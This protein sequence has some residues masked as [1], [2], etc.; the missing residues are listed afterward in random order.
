MSYDKALYKSTVTY[1]LTY[2]L[3]RVIDEMRWLG[4]MQ[5]V[6]ACVGQGGR[7]VTA[8]RWM[9]ASVR[10]VRTVPSVSMN[11]TPTSV[12]VHISSPVSVGFCH[13]AAQSTN[14][15]ILFT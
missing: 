1:L 11:A 8:A 2:L 15:L 5:P 14:C 7:E 10:R 4:E 12:H 9:R 13:P 6:C 3:T